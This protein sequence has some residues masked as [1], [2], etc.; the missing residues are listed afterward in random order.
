MCTQIGNALSRAICAACTTASWSAS[1]ARSTLHSD[2][3][4]SKEIPRMVERVLAGH[5]VFQHGAVLGAVKASSLRSDAAFRGASDL[6]RA[7]AQRNMSGYM[8]ARHVRACTQL[9]WTNGPDDSR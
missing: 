1:R 3:H 9:H 7:S 2:P 8:M 4:L 5:H 6:D